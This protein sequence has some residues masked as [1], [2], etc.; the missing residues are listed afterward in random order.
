MPTFPRKNIRS[1]RAIRARFTTGLLSVWSSAVPGKLRAWFHALTGRTPFFSCIRERVN[2]GSARFVQFGMVAAIRQRQIL[3]SIVCLVSVEVVDK[4]RALQWASN[5]LSHYP[6]M[7]LASNSVDADYS[8][9]LLVNR[10]VS[11]SHAQYYSNKTLTF[12]VR[13]VVFSSGAA[14]QVA[15]QP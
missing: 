12:Y 3:G 9:A 11:V 2:R 1:A 15:I 6:S 10:S 7:L 14:Q 4:F 5:Y 13:F 8:V